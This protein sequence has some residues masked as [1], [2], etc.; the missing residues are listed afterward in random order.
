MSTGLFGRPW[1]PVCC[2]LRHHLLSPL[3]SAGEKVVSSLPMRASAPRAQNVDPPTLYIHVLQ[4]I[5]CTYL[6]MYK[7][8]LIPVAY[9]VHVHYTVPY[10]VHNAVIICPDLILRGHLLII[11]RTP[12][13][14]PDR[15]T[16]LTM[17]FQQRHL[18]NTTVIALYT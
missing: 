10:Q 6:Y 16:V 5:Q 13:G 12:W 2:R 18:S 1:K 9:N 15:P 3:V 4:Y 8:G 17:R 14:C 7:Y 11:S